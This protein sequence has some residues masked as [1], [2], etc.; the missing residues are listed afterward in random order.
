MKVSAKDKY[1]YL[2][3]KYYNGKEGCFPALETLSKNFGLSI[4]TIRNC[5]DRLEEAGYIQI[6][7]VGRKHYYQF[8]KYINFEPFSPEF[9][10]SKE[11]STGIKVYIIGL[12]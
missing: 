6:K 9:L 7:K 2:I 10:K 11:I 1:V 4:N 12:Q 8:T 3:L 5:I